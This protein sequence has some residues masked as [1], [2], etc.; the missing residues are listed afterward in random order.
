MLP[1][2]KFVVLRKEDLEYEKNLNFRQNLKRRVSQLEEEKAAEK[3]A[4]IL[5]VALG[6]KSEASSSNSWCR[7]KK[8]G[9]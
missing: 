7:N 8:F 3:N 2:K 5:D 6:D 1:S 9:Q 4:A